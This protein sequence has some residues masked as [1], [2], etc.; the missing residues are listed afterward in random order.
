MRVLQWWWKKEGSS[1]MSGEVKLGGFREGESE[2]V[3]ASV[4]I[5]GRKME[6]GF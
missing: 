6:I 1:L 2:A 5:E 3:V 4:I